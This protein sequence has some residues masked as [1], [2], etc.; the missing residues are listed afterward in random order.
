MKGIKLPQC[1]AHCGYSLHVSIL[2]PTHSDAL[3]TTCSGENRGKECGDTNEACH[4]AIKIPFPEL[5]LSEFHTL[6]F[7]THLILFHLYRGMYPYSTDE[8]IRALRLNNLTSVMEIAYGGA[9]ICVL[10][11]GSPKARFL[12]TRGGLWPGA[13]ISYSCPPVSPTCEPHLHDTQICNPWDRF[14]FW[15]FIY[16]HGIKSQLPF[17]NW[18]LFS[19]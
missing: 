10:V 15:T 11:P 13:G 12:T 5:R 18:L 7:F 16:T 9:R 19:H 14:T 3:L 8:E 6:T 4:A 17:C 1:Q 2:Y